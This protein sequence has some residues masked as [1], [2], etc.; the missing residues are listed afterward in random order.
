MNANTLPTLTCLGKPLDLSPNAFGQLRRSDD[1]AH[2]GSALRQRMCEEGYLYLPGL[3]DPA[4]VLGVRRHVT[5]RLAELGLLDERQPRLD[6]SYRP[7]GGA[8]KSSHDL[9]SNNP[10]LEHLLYSGAMMDYYR[11]FLGGPVRH[12][13]FTWFRAMG[14]GH[15]TYPHCDIVYMGRGTSNLYT[16]W[17]PI[18]DVPISVG[19]LMILEGSNRQEARLRPYLARDVDAYCTNRP[20]AADIESGAKVWQDWD[21]RLTS[22]PVTLREKLGGR[23]LTTDYKAGDFLCFGMGTVHASLDNHSDRIRLSSDSR[24]Q[25]ASEP[26]DER[27]IG[28]APV[29]HG[30]AGKRGKAC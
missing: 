23:W 30:V 11:R 21:G 26:A 24:Y 7:G 15:G 4:E 2:A 13:D 12:F 3:L 9:A 1:I 28:A 18:G 14:P 6:S 16:S 22:N 25:L 17:T 20:D 5:D 8:L 29:G 10:L 27:W 19:G